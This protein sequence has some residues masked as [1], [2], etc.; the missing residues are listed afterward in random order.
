MPH[1]LVMLTSSHVKA[2]MRV[3]GRNPSKKFWVFRESC[4]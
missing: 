2:I 1:V 4:G 3:A